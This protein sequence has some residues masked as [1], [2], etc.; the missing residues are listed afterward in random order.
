MNQDLEELL[1]AYDAY[2]AIQKA[3]IA[4]VIGGLPGTFG[5]DRRES[6]ES[7]EERIT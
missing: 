5:S 2:A 7:I 3:G 6:P 1:N 4:E